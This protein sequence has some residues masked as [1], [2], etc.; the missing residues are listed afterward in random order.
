L[1]SGVSHT[2]FD[3]T[4][5]VEVTSFDEQV[6]P[7]PPGMALCK[8]V[9]ANHFPGDFIAKHPFM[10]GGV[11]L[12]ATGEC[13]RRYGCVL[14]LTY[15]TTILSPVVSC[16]TESYAKTPVTICTTVLGLRDEVIYD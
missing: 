5:G 8:D 16:S 1:Q 15:M 11:V 14:C 4:I 6:L 13:V 9:L 7:S 2:S 12:D 10:A 3:A